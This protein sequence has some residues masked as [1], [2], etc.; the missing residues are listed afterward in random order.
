MKY[1]VLGGL[2]AMA[3]A[4]AQEEVS[5]RAR[6]MVQDG[7]VTK[8]SGGATLTNGAVRIQADSIVYNRAAGEAEAT[9]NVRIQFLS[10]AGSPEETQPARGNLSLEQRMMRMMRSFPPEIIAPQ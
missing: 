10:K 2:L 4:F 5:I 7:A 8:A 6:E 1:M 9:G 3:T